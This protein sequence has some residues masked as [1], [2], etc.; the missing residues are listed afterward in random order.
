MPDDG[1]QII[2]SNPSSDDAN[3]GVQ[4]K[5]EV[6]PEIPARDAYITNYTD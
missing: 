3:I 5:N 4:G 1:V 6:P 2:E